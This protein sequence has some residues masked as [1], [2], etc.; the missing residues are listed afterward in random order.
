MNME[1]LGNTGQRVV[2]AL[3]ILIVVIVCL[4]W[5]RIP[6]LFFVGFFGLLVVDEFYCNFFRQVR[7]SPFYV[8]AHTLFILLYTAFNLHFSPRIGSFVTSGCLLINGFLLIH[9]LRQ[10]MNSSLLQRMST[11]F[12]WASGFFVALLFI[13]LGQIFHFPH[14]RTNLGLMIII[15]SGMDTGAW[16]FGRKFGKKQLMPSVS[17]KK[18]VEGFWGGIVVASLLASIFWY[19]RIDQLS[20][21]HPAI[22]AFLA[23]VSQMG[24]LVQSKIKRQFQLKDSSSLIPGHGGVYDRLDSLL[25]MAPFFV[26][27]LDLVWT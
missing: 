6:S 23:A 26:L 16:F 27:F 20:W 15:T 22:F 13:P 17:P 2:S 5:G 24:D 25:F 7:W 9:L 10:K 1:K 19:W 8:I 4:Q 11:N 14:F 3:V 18:T 12:P 21:F